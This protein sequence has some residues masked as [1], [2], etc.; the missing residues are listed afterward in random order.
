LRKIKEY[1]LARSLEKHL[2]KSR[3]LELYLNVVKWV[4]AFTARRQLRSYFHTSASSLNPSQAGAA[5]WLPPDP[6][7]DESR[8]ANK[9]LRARQSIILARLRRWDTAVESR[10]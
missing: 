9:R 8:L 10:S 6:R 2:S 4:S 7:V 3:I 5:G 1:F